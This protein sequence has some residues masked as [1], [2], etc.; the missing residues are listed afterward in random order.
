MFTTIMVVL[1]SVYAVVLGAFGL[2]LIIT[3]GAEIIRAKMKGGDKQ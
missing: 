1:S 3:G 2:Y